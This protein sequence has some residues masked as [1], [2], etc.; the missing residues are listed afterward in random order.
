MNKKARP[1]TVATLT[2]V[3]G[4]TPRI[5]PLGFALAIT[6]RDADDVGAVLDITFDWSWMFHLADRLRFVLEKRAADTQA[7]LDRLAG[8]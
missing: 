6:G 3:S 4:I 8:K 7:M 1:V 2:K 5:T